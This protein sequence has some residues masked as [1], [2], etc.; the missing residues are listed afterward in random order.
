MSTTLY[1]DLV[2]EVQLFTES[3]PRATIIEFVRRA[4]ITLCRQSRVW[5]IAGT[6]TLVPGEDDVCIRN[7]VNEPGTDEKKMMV[8]EELRYDGKPLGRRTAKQISDLSDRLGSVQGFYQ[9]DLH[10]VNLVSVPDAFYENDDFIEYSIS[11][12]PSEASTGMD[13]DLLDRYR[14][15]IVAGAVGRLFAMPK[16]TW[17]NPEFAEQYLQQFAA[18][19]QEATTD[20]QQEFGRRIPRVVKYGGI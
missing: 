15:G 18:S 11:V 14:H 12:V 16:K 7:W 8:I 20:A 4:C 6:E 9:S 5:R 10:I 17:S 19:V 13:T 1:T 2:D 3:V